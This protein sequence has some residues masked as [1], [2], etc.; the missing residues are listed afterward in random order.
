VL[1][2]NGAAVQERVGG[3]DIKMRIVGDLFG[4]GEKRIHALFR[5][6]KPLFKIS[7]HEVIEEMT[8]IKMTLGFE[9]EGF[10]IALPEF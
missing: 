9:G 7:I 4:A 6:L 3:G 1:F 5:V 10:R 2:Q 8:V